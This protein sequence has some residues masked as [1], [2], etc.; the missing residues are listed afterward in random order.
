MV[1]PGRELLVGPVEVDETLIGTRRS[2][3]FGGGDVR[4]ALVAIAVERRDG[5]PGRVPCDAS[6][7]EH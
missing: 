6:P 7:R 1:M 3:T 4:K 5:R 2:G